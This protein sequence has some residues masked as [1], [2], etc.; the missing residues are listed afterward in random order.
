MHITVTFTSLALAGEKCDGG[1]QP[2]ATRRQVSCL[3]NT[4]ASAMT[5]GSAC[6]FGS[7]IFFFFK[8]CDLAIVRLC[9][10]FFFPRCFCFQ[11]AQPRFQQPL[12]G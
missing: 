6:I 12:A 8:V 11:K 5:S 7:A 9:V 3:D 10:F 2:H 1:E 4:I